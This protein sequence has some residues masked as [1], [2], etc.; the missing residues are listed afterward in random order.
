L[1]KDAIIRIAD[2]LRATDFYSPKHA[3]IYSAII[4]LYEHREPIDILSLSNK[5]KDQNNLDNAGGESTVA[6]LAAAVPTAG[7]VEH[8][9]RIVQKKATLRRLISAAANIS[10]LGFNEE[11]EVNLVLDEAEQSLFAVSQQHLRQSFV[12]MKTVLTEAFHRI[13]SLHKG[14][15][16]LRGLPTGFGPL[17]NLLSGLQRSD[18]IILAARP[19][20]GKTS[21]ALDIARHISVHEKAPVGI[22]SL[23]MSKEQLADRFICA[24]AGVDLWKMRTGH[25]SSDGFPDDDFSHINRAMATLSEAPIFIDDSASSNIMEIRTLARRLQSEHGI[26]FLV[27]DYLQL[28]EGDSRDGRVQE[29]SQISRALKSLARELNVPILALSQLSRAV[30]ARMPPVP[31]LSDLRESGSIEQDADVVLF[32]YPRGKHEKTAESPNIVDAIIAKHRNGP[33]GV[34]SLYFREESASFAAID[35]QHYQS[36]EPVR[37][38]Q[39]SHA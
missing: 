17:D 9:A 18:L 7:H 19:S 28:L 33:T 38:V 11:S 12:P 8:Y 27:I 37:S 31:K 23:E 13:D 4:E 2:F 1:N 35:T 16:N 3:L 39:K 14:D 6:S 21:L 20:V 22:F 5:L 15:G 29:V 30:E 32:L 36:E 34:I 24:E 26:G 25:L 10:E